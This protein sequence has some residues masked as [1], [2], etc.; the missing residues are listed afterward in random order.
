MNDM[1]LDEWFHHEYIEKLDDDVNKWWTDSFHPQEC[2]H[3]SKNKVNSQVI[4]KSNYKP[5]TVQEVIESHDNLQEI[6][7]ERLLDTLS[8]YEKLFDE[9]LWLYAGKP[10][11]FQHSC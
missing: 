3:N 2:L 8:P 9:K 4:K 10:L 11:H 7:K 5:H 1:H 6:I